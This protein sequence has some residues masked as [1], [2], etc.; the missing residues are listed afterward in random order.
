MS[1]ILYKLVDDKPVKE[2]VKAVDVA[3]LLNNGYASTPEQ[4]IK[5][6]EVD[7]NN[8]GKLSDAEIKAAAVEAG[9]KIGKKSIK[10]LKKE[11]SL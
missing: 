10:T 2:S 4:L 9:I 11:L 1:C 6:K 3:C 7:T 5:R 8:S